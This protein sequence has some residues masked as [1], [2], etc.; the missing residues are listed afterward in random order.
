MCK[1]VQIENFDKA[2][3]FPMERLKFILLVLITVAN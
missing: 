1:K 2:V 3:G